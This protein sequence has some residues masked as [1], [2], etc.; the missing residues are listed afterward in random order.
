MTIVIERDPPPS[1]VEP[2]FREYAGSLSFD[3]GFQGFEA[4]VAGL[5]GPYSRPT[6]ALLIARADGIPA[7]CVAIRAIDEKTGELKRL[8]VG[9]AH[10]GSGIGR[11]LAT[12]AIEVARELGY[13]RLRLDTTPEMTA[14]HELYRALG[15]REIEPY[16]H[17]PVPGT[18][19]LELDLRGSPPAR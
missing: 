9:T 10:R 16:R 11:Q 6:G 1:E 8:F 3:L 2:L 12:A 17:N 14:A 19:Y 7:G 15:F 13:E 5:P 4:E 18:R